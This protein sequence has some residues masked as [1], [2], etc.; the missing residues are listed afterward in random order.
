MIRSQ[1]NFRS[2]GTPRLPATAAGKSIVGLSSL[3]YPGYSL[4][5]AVSPAPILGCLFK[6]DLTTLPT[7]YPILVNGDGT[8]QITAGGDT[9]R[10]SFIADLYDIRQEGFVGGFTVYENERAPVWSGLVNLTL[11]PGVAIAPIDLTLICSSPSGDVLSFAVVNT[12]PTGLSMTAA[13]LIS[14]TPTVQA[15]YLMQFDATDAAGITTR[16]AQSQITIAATSPDGQPTLL[17][18]QATLAG[19]YNGEYY[20]IGDV[21]DIVPIVFSDSSIDALAGFAGGPDPG[22][23]TVVPSTTA[24]Y[25]SNQTLRNAARRTVF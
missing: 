20:D 8:F 24:L 9:S 2:R 1:R 14:G 17:R 12:L 23:M 21:F 10:Q 15:I 19:F 6:T 18:V 7:G 22:W 25:N 4:Q 5:S 16:S 13:G 3:T 11:A